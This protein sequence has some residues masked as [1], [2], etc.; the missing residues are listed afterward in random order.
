VIRCVGC[1][2]R[3]APDAQEC[4]WCARPFKESAS[5]GRQVWPL[6]AALVVTLL[7]VALAWW[8]LAATGAS[9]QRRASPAAATSSLPPTPTRLPAA[10][11]TPLPRG[12]QVVIV[13]TD[14]QGASLRSEPAAGSQRLTVLLEGS[15]VR[16]VGPEVLDGDHAW[17]E[18]Q[19]DSGHRGWVQADLVQPLDTGTSLPG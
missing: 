7:L 12:G 8:T 5:R 1:G 2:G 16:V 4:E 10:V 6:V 11:P 9:V 19:D 13:N 3:N 15:V 17:V 18:V 14:G